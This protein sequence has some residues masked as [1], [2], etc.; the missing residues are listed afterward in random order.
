M[1]WWQNLFARDEQSTAKREPINPKLG[2]DPLTGEIDSPEFL[3]KLES[4]GFNFNARRVWWERIWTTITPDYVYPDLKKMLEVY[5][6]DTQTKIWTH[7]VV[8]PNFL[9]GAGGGGSTP[10]CFL[11]SE[12]IGKKV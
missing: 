5:S 9:G 10:E 8:D 3:T 7:Q 6:F 11:W 4:K 2:Y 12:E 1:T